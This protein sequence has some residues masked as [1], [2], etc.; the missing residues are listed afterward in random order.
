VTGLLTVAV[1]FCPVSYSPNADQ[2]AV[3]TAFLTCL[4]AF[5][6]FLERLT[7]TVFSKQI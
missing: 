6:A 7:A 5:L 2:L 4:G 3:M 1:Y